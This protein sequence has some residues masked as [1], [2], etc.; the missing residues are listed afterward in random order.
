MCA[1]LQ[2]QREALA[3]CRAELEALLEE[4]TAAELAATDAY[5]AGVS[6]YQEQLDAGHSA[7]ADA[8]HALRTTC[9]HALMPRLLGESCLVPA[10][11]PESGGS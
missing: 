2:E 7:E 6:Q 11:V 1:R 9:A 8:Y 4:R 3:A 10:G 5:C